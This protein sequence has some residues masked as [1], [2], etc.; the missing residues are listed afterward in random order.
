MKC[1]GG[2]DSPRGNSESLFTIAP[3]FGSLLISS[4]DLSLPSDD[5][6]LFTHLENISDP[7]LP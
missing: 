5:S 7:T 3:K 6:V 2:Y 1:G 4:E